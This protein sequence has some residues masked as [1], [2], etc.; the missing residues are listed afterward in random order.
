[1]ERPARR[2]RA[3]RGNLRQSPRSR[4]QHLDADAFHGMGQRSGQP[5]MADPQGWLHALRGSGLPQGLPGARR[6]RAICQR[7]RRFHQREL[8]RLR[9]L[10]Q[11]L[12]VRHSSRQQ[13]RSQ[14][15]QM[16]A[17]LRSRRGWQRA[18]LREG[19]S[20]RR[21]H[22]RLED[23]H[24]VL[25][26][27][28]RDRSQVARLRE[29]GPLR[30]AGRRRH[31]CDVRAASRRPSVALCRTAGQSEDQRARRNLEGRVEAAGFGRRR[32]RRRCADFSTGSPPGQTKCSPRTTSRRRSS[33]GNRTAKSRATPHEL[34]AR[35]DHSQ[36]DRGA[37]QSLDHRRLL[38][39]ADAFRPVDV[40]PA[41]VLSRFAVRQRAMGARDSSVDRLRA[42]W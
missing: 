23:G 42:A 6:D 9:L 38:R 12:S 33:F 37:D 2:D 11:G 24:D 5:R 40:P 36:Y 27:R 16:H 18:G 13:D 39:S 26:R 4:S 10:H 17:L 30:S 35:D 32:A 25:G 22:V 15:L 3:F 31:A 14:I 20:D 34:S 41:L 21:D 7:H 8:H 19:L 1:M 28:A 29:R